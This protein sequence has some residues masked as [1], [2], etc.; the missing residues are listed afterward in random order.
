MGVYIDEVVY[1]TELIRVDAQ[2]PILFDKLREPIS[3]CMRLLEK[4]KALEHVPDIYRDGFSWD[5]AVCRTLVGDL[6]MDELPLGRIATLGRERL[7][8]DFEELFDKLQIFLNREVSLDFV[9]CTAAKVEAKCGSS[10]S[11]SYSP[12]SPVY[13]T[14]SPTLAPLPFDSS[15]PSPARPP[16]TSSIAP[17]LNHPS[18]SSSVPWWMATP[19]NHSST[20]YRRSAKP[21]LLSECPNIDPYLLPNVRKWLAR[22]TEGDVFVD[23]YESLVGM[24]ENQT[25]FV[26]KRGYIGIGPPDTCASDQIWVFKGGNVPFVMRDAG[27]EGRKNHQLTLVGDAYVHGIMD[28]EAVDSQ[29]QMQSVWIM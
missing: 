17:N 1:T 22:P 27:S 26:T 9:P 18:E 20:F 16:P 21:R 4:Y 15:P 3:K 6:I 19:S 12:S 29:L 7:Q 11:P 24:M 23:L 13:K 5:S 8:S 25:F 28:G 2:E 14:P 10:I